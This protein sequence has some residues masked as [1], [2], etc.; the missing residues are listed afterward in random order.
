MRQ[1]CKLNWGKFYFVSEL[2]PTLC[3]RWQLLS[4]LRKSVGKQAGKAKLS[5]QTS[6]T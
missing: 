5:K 3:L 6:I 4:I 1:K 2:N